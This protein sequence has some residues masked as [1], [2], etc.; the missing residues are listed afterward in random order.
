M[1]DSIKANLI[2]FF[3]IAIISFAMSSAFASLTIHEQND[4]YKLIAIQNDSFEP[5]YIDA[6]P[7]Y[8]PPEP[9][10]DTN[11]TYNNTT[12]FD[13]SENTTNWTET[14]TYTDYNIETYVE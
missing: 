8:I 4:S 11:I 9:V 13:Y 5:H 12:D 3:L 6:V 2:V 10:N 1:K 7:T 14:Y